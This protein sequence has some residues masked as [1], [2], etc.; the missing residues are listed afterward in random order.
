MSDG[1]HAIRAMIERAMREGFK[2]YWEPYR[3]VKQAARVEV[4]Q[5][6]KDGSLS[7]RKGVF[8][9]CADCGQLFKDK[10][11]EVDHVEPVAPPGKRKSDLS[12]DELVARV[13]VTEEFL[14]VLCKGAGSCHSKKT[15]RQRLAAVGRMAST[16]S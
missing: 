6:N 12:L 14:Q 4:D 16:K 2:R 10:F 15:Q 11:V 1:Y 13:F 9:K 5:Y 3:N 7:K 8:Y